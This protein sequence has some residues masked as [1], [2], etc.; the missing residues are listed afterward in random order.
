MLEHGLVHAVVQ[1]DFSF[2]PHITDPGLSFLSPLPSPSPLALRNLSNVTFPSYRLLPSIKSSHIP[3][4]L[5]FFPF[6]FLLSVSHFL[7][8]SFVP[9]FSSTF[10][11]NTFLNIFLCVY[12]PHPRFF[13]CKESPSP[14]LSADLAD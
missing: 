1:N 5:Y 14:V 4:P 11:N 7:S 9:F 13:L 6:G 10:F 3:F 8:Q 12:S 2:V